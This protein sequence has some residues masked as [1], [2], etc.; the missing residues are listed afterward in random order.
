MDGFFFFATVLDLGIFLISLYSPSFSSCCKSV[1]L[2]I[3]FLVFSF[4]FL[5]LIHE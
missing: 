5:F 4:L 1:D 3:S 2:G